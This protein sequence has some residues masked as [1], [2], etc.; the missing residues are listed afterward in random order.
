MKQDQTPKDQYYVA[1]IAREFEGASLG[2]RRLEA[3][4]LKVVEAIA[5]APH[6]SLPQAAASA[7]D[8]QGAYRFLANTA[9]RPEALLQPH[10]E[11][12]VQRCEKARVVIVAHDSSEIEYDGLVRRKGLGFLRSESTQGFFAH[13]SLAMAA[14]GTRLPLGVLGLHCWTRETL[15][16]SKKDGRK[17]TQ[18][19]YAQREAKESDRWGAQVKGTAQQVGGRA[20]LI[21]VMDREADAFP[22]LAE[23]TA[24]HHRFVIRATYAR[25]ARADEHS[26]K[27]TM[28]TIVAQAQG[29]LQTE[30]PV[31]AR[32]ASGKPARDQTFQPR[33]SRQAT[34]EFSACTLHLKRPPHAL[35]PEWLPINVV[36]VREVDAPQGLEP[37]E[38]F[39]YTSEPV[40]TPEQVVQ[41][42]EHYRSRWVIEEFYKALKTG[43]SLEDRQLESYDALV[44]ALCIFI[45]MAWQMLLLRTLAR[46]KPDAAATTVL[47]STQIEVLG[48][49]GKQRLPPL[50][51]VKQALLAIATMGGYIRTKR[52]PGWLVLGR[53]MEKLLLLEAGWTARQAQEGLACAVPSRQPDPRSAQS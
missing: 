35:G 11:Q 52:G 41:V 12:T 38:W 26:P 39:L 51:T 15:G 30:V 49:C 24:T 23:L 42:V 43:C 16:K 9:V 1:P 28:P 10:I 37:I 3:R 4:L 36:H 20:E 27:E 34:V 2:D 32:P 8:L 47:S 45:P 44:N 48:A 19:E 21:H 50:P 18:R 25:A 13:T 31:S 46:T 53:G 40:D 7:K 17:L 6:R 22:L 33:E 5:P 29:V 14:D